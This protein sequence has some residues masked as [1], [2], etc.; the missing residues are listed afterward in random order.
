MILASNKK[1]LLIELGSKR[2][3]VRSLMASFVKI[4][5]KNFNE[6]PLVLN[7]IQEDLYYRICDCFS[8]SKPIRFIILKARQLGMTTFIAGLIFILT[9]FQK[10]QKAVIVADK[11]E[12]A[13]EIFQKYQLF[14]RSLPVELQGKLRSDNARRLQSE[15]YGSSIRVLTQGDDIGRGST[16]SY[17]HLSEASGYDNLT[18]TINAINNAVPLKNRNT[19]IFIESTAKGFNEFKD[20]WDGAIAHDNYYIPIFYPRYDNPDYVDDPITE[21]LLP[22]ESDLIKKFNLTPEQIGWYHSQYLGVGKNLDLL[23]QENPSEPIEAF[24]TSGSNVFNLEKISERKKIVSKLKGR[25]GT[26]SVDTNGSNFNDYRVSG[27]FIENSNGEIRILKEPESGH[28]YVIGIDYAR[29]NGIDYTCM[30]VIDNSTLEQVAIYHKKNEDCDRSSAIAILLGN[31]YNN[32]LLVPETNSSEFMIKFFIKANYK[33]VYIRE[34]SDANFYGQFYERYGVKTSVLNKKTMIDYLVE[35]CRESDYNLINDFL[36]LSEMESFVYEE[37][38]NGD[39]VKMGASGKSHDDT[40]M[41]LALAYYGRGQ[42]TSLVKESVKAPIGY[43]KGFDPL[44]LY[45]NNE[46]YNEV[47]WDD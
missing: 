43:D 7:P 9:M 31:M 12:N 44:N 14:Y 38:K 13:V 6:V 20:F 33:N 26:F 42:K 16:I 23:H 5:D 30:Q 35:V 34:G 8:K 3:S 1:D 47:S 24:I 22:F 41:A 27:K 17:V 32:A 4:I 40:V 46:I 45:H 11:S 36:T 29:G 18:L 37:S 39:N 28:P 2:Y 10:N 19:M 15:F 21:N 25:I